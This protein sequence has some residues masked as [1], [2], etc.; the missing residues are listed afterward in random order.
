MTEKLYIC[1]HAGS[2]E[3]PYP[4][5]DWREPHEHKS[6]YVPGYFY[7]HPE[8]GERLTVRCIPVEGEENPAG[9]EE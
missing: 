2:V 9:E 1:D 7:C 8:H 4:D 3:C 6:D 5:C